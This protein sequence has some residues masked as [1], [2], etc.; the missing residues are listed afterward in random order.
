MAYSVVPDALHGQ[1]PL[2]NYLRADTSSTGHRWYTAKW[3]TDSQI[4]VAAPLLL[5]FYDKAALLCTLACTHST[6]L[7]G[8]VFN[9]LVGT[10]RAN[11]DYSET[12]LESTTATL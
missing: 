2:V 12:P 3:Y 5:L 10:C 9:H 6:G 7:E 1:S 4:E 11:L 8:T